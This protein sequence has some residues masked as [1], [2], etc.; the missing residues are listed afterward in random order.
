MEGQE[1][2]NRLR[3]LFTRGVAGLG[4]LVAWP[5]SNPEKGLD[6]CLAATSVAVF[7]VQR[8]QTEKLFICM[9]VQAGLQML[10]SVVRI[11]RA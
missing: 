11:C 2:D 3:N 5:F 9:C 10:Q 6:I 1:E 7:M 8:E 4:W